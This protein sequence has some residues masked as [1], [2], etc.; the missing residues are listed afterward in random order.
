MQSSCSGS[1][2]G[3]TFIILSRFF[4]LSGRR[5]SAAAASSSDEQLAPE[6]RI[7][8]RAWPATPKCLVGRDVTASM[9]SSALR[10]T[11]VFSLSLSSSLPLS[12]SFFLSRH[13]SRWRLYSSESIFPALMYWVFKPDEAFYC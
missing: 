12:S 3:Q 9:L 5:D 1:L 4:S 8:T 7:G 10:F 11:H 13:N 6:G 2:G